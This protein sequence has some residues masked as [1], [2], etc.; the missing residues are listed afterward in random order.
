MDDDITFGSVWATDIAAPTT[1]SPPPAAFSL[2]TL[3]DDDAFDDFGEPSAQI[4]APGDDEDDFGD[5]GDFGDA[6]DHAGFVDAGFEE[7]THIA[8]PSSS[9]LW[10]CLRLDPLPPRTELE[11]RIEE[12]LGPL[13]RHGNT[14]QAMTDDDIR[15]V[16]GLNQI[17]ITPER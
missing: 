4:V 12:I 7:Q 3:D 9:G 5:F 16:G 10:Q 2:P 6:D 8:G 1:L 11:E 14:L 17:L 15:E 13:W